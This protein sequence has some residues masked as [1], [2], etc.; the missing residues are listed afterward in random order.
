VR[1]EETR[2]V[3]V[4]DKPVNGHVSHLALARL[5]ARRRIRKKYNRIRNQNYTKLRRDVSA[6]SGSVIV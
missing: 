3:E 2:K 5:A 6:G 4:A 1:S